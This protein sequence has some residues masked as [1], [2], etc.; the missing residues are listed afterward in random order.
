MV[1]TNLITFEIQFQNNGSES[2]IFN[3][4]TNSTN[5]LLKILKARK[6]YF[7]K[8]KEFDR[9]KSTFKRVSKD[10]LLKCIAFNTELHEIL[11]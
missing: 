3:T 9:V 6:L 5:E 1:S 4:S 2:F 11:K 10:R 7:H 8:V